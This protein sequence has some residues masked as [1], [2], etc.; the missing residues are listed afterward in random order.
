MEK[1]ILHTFETFYPNNIIKKRKLE[2]LL[3]GKVLNDGYTRSKKGGVIQVEGN[4]EAI[5]KFVKHVNSFY[6]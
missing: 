2:K 6:K 1:E 4:L 5:G 3:G